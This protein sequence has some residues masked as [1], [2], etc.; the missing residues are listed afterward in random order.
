MSTD[1]DGPLIRVAE[2]PVETEEEVELHK[3]SLYK[4]ILLNDDYTPMDFVVEVLQK[5]FKKDREAATRI[6]LEVHNHGKG[7]CGVY[8]YDIAE[9]KVHQ[10]LEYARANEHPL[11]CTMEKE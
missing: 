2:P 1:G 3:P 6:M 8:P 11:Q 7:V 9:T 10:V 5:F 4:V